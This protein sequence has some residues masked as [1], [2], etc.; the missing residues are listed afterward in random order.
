MTNL[1]RETIIRDIEM[2]YVVCLYKEKNEP[3]LNWTETGEINF[4]IMHIN[5]L[6]VNK[7]EVVLEITSAIR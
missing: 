3:V 5:V 6:K 7:I 1:Q 4:L 2:M